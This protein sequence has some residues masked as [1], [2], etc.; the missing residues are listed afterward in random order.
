MLSEVRGTDEEHSAALDRL[1]PASARSELGAAQRGRIRHRRRHEVAAGLADR[2]RRR[3]T[4]KTKTLAHRVAHLILNGADPHRLLLLTFTR[5]AA[6]EMTRRAHQILAEARSDGAA[7]A[8]QTAA[9][10]WSG[11]FHSVGSRLL[12][13]HALSIGLDASFTILDRSDA[14]D[15]LDL[16]RTELGLFRAA[17]RFPARTPA[18]RSTPTRSMPGAP[19]TRR[20]PKFSVVCGLPERA[21]SAVRGLCRGQAAGQRPR[22]R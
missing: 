15:L 12:G 22:L 20:L 18:W 2:G 13:L 16:V 5:R 19:S 10:P 1:S 6:L 4:G 17:S 21:S 9:L 3:R 14:A 7:R 11:T 8:S